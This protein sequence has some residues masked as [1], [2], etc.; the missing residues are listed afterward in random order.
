MGNHS[1]TSGDPEATPGFQ[2]NVQP[3]VEA[4]EPG[5]AAKYHAGAQEPPAGTGEQGELP[6]TYGE[7]TIYLV[8]QDPR[9][10]FTYW[11]LDISRH[12][13]GP[14][15]IRCLKGETAELEVEF[16]VPF[17]ARNWY[18]PVNSSGSLY[19]VE[20]GFYRSGKWN[21][22]ATSE[23]VSTPRDSVSDDDSFEFA[24]LPLDTAFSALLSS[25]P[26]QVRHHPE[27][28]RHL[29]GLQKKQA[30]ASLP[31][32]STT[33]NEEAMRLLQSLLGDSLLLQLLS[34][35]WDSA[36]L[37]SAIQTRL[38]EA[39][40][41]GESSAL[42]A[43]FE[44][45]ASES[46]LF[47]GLVHFA[48]ST[49]SASSE[50]L[51]SG[52]FGSE[53]LTSWTESLLSWAHAARHAA[54]SEWLSTWQLAP[55]GASSG[56]LSSQAPLQL[57]SASSWF[58]LFASSWGNAGPSGLSSGSLSPAQ[59]S[60][61]GE[62]L[63]SWSTSALSSWFGESLSSW[64][65]ESLS[66]WTKELLTS[67]T[68]A[69]SGSWPTAPGSREFFM[70]VN[71]ELIFYGGTH[72]DASLTIDGKTVK[73]QPDGTFHHHFI[74]PD[75]TYEIPIIATSPDGVETRKAVL[76]FERATLREG[77][78]DATGQPPLPRPMG[79]K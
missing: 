60:W 35:S 2:I 79:R 39:L 3:L 55:G 7:S 61:T 58:S 40:S 53:T 33:R 41:S 74:F 10:L 30:A 20:I 70:H 56:E 17:E 31:S 75:G 32:T 16:E 42:L 68:S 59:S 27:L 12:P 52:A 78:V 23:V 76:R 25:L 18:I 46:S 47:S 8:A 50:T 4:D 26:P 29:A 51:S 63:S 69:E 6:K 77:K 22:L 28:M 9:R 66:S 38:G 44:E 71:A 62:S 54:A 13:G 43:R 37:S 64:T 1:K 15:V 34:G 48:S 67:W 24:T 14:A 49:G 73:L 45:A 19:R 5:G 72:P 36:A 21:L 65:A 57:A 11:D